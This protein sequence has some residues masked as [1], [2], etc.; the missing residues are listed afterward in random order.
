MAQVMPAKVG[1]PGFLAGALPG[2]D[3]RALDGV[4]GVG[5]HKLRMLAPAASEHFSRVVVER[6]G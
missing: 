2:E 3:V 4:P 6:Y 1:D 5:E